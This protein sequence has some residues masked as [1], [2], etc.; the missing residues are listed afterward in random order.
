MQV[1]KTWCLEL[2]LSPA[3]TQRYCPRKLRR[4]TIPQEILHTDNRLLLASDCSTKT[5]QLN[6]F[7]E[8]FFILEWRNESQC[9]AVLWLKCITYDMHQICTLVLLL[10]LCLLGSWLSWLGFVHFLFWEQPLLFSG[11]VW[12]ACPFSLH[13]P[14]PRPLLFH[15]VWVLIISH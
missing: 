2:Q 9:G 7:R 13:S 1:T 4:T 11:H 3:Q 6:A 12:T 15:S 5:W 10:S 8:V 14:W